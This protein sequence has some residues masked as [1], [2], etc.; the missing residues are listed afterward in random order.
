MFLINIKLF[1][2]F[3]DPH[4]SNFDRTDCL[5][6]CEE[7]WGPCGREVDGRRVIFM[8]P[9]DGSDPSREET[10]DRWKLIFMYHSVYLC[11]LEVDVKNKTVAR[12]FGTRANKQQTTFLTF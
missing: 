12:P 8:G 7:R 1:N 2:F 9:L 10:C 11:S 4:V 6:G 5:A 3:N